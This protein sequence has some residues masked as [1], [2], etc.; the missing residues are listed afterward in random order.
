M[1]DEAVP[2]PDETAGSEAIE[3][4]EAVAKPESVA[5]AEEAAGGE[6]VAEAEEAA[7]GEAIAE[8]PAPTAAPLD[9]IEWLFEQPPSNFTLQIAVV[10][11][12][13]NAESF[14]RRQRSRN[15]YIFYPIQHGGER[16]F[17]I[18]RG[19]YPNRAAAERAAAELPPTAG[20]PAPWIRRM[21]EVQ[22]VA[23]GS[24]GI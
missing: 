16:R 5:E 9:P 2:K 7:G 3:E 15:G 8:E 23:R 14:V 1:E 12:A 11:S 10:S 22:A 4:H 6:T 21:A 19:S 13:A 17:V 20:M 24:H 18:L